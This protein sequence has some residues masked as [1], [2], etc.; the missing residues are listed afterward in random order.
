MSRIAIIG[1]SYLQLPLVVKAKEMGLE[2]HVFAWEQG[3]VC[4]E[5][6]DYFYPIS[7]TDINSIL[8]ICKKIKPIGVISIASDI[9]SVTV[10][11]IADKF[12]LIGN[13]FESTRLSTNKFLMRTEFLNNGL[14]CPRFMK[15]TEPFNSK[16]MQELNYPLIVKP[17]D[18]SG[19]RGVTL[20]N[21]FLHLNA[22]IKEAEKESFSNTVIIE[23]FI[24]GRE[25][26]VETISWEGCHY[27]L[28]Y[29]DK[30]TTGKPHFIEKAQHQ[31]A[32]LAPELKNKIYQIVKHGLDTLKI[33]YGAS[34]T[35]LK[36]TPDDEV[37]IIETGPRMGGDHIGARLVPLSTGYDYLKAVINVSMGKFEEPKL[38]DDKYS[39]IYY[40]FPKPGVLNAV[41]FN[42]DEHIVEYD[43]LINIG[44]IVE[45]IK[46]SSQRAAYYIYQSDYKPDFNPHALILTTR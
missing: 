35:E 16:L 41:E 34:H 20:V 8:D 37:F 22:A 30:E 25:I 44:E 33:K 19:S 45:D 42:N 10:N 13:S 26:S 7:V 1:A 18:R 28:Q 9:A 43:V 39:G 12:G 27:I 24:D 36:I 40:I 15:Y 32:K 4:K 11:H 23:E 38:L 5:A 6:A 21:E 46:D 17:V 14:P 29:T 3:A 31:P 2:T